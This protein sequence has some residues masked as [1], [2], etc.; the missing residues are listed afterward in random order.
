MATQSS[1]ELDP[2]QPIKQSTVTPL[3]IGMVNGIV[4]N[5]N[6]KTLNGHPIDTIS[7]VC[8]VEE[9]KGSDSTAYESLFRDDTGI[10][11]GRVF[12]SQG[13]A[14]KAIAEYHWVAHGYAHVIG[15]LNEQ[16]GNKYI[17]INFMKNIENYKEVSMHKAQVIWAL[18]IRNNVLK[19]PETANQHSQMDLVSE[20]FAGMSNEQKMVAKVIKD[21]SR[22]GSVAK[23]N[24]YKLVRLI[25]A[26]IDQELR[27]LVDFGFIIADSN[28]ES[29]SLV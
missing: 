22:S 9:F 5:G 16:N 26:R 6:A 14:I 8:R 11:K 17:V 15:T 7:L 29:F 18:L 20:D 28:F 24:I 3:T 23:A 21:Y 13:A 4:N 27:S 12:K 10:I 19:L 25:P 2:M 1:R